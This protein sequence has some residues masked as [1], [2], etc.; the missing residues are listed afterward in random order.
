MI[1][2]ADTILYFGI[3]LLGIV[4]FVYELYHCIK[5]KD[6]GTGV[7]AYVFLILGIYFLL[8]GIAV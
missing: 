2:I 8:R 1:D 7:I 5:Y 4:G 3:A 6:V